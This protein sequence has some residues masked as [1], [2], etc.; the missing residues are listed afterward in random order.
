M[1]IHYF[2]TLKNLFG[3]AHL[4]RMKIGQPDGKLMQQIY[5]C[6][7][8]QIQARQNYVSKKKPESLMHVC[9]CFIF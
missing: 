7:L 8:K 6:H 9:Y 2:K 1:I 4:L 5:L 3:Q